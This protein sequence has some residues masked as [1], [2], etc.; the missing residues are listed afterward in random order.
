MSERIDA[1]K[2][3]WTN[4]GRAGDLLAAG[5]SAA[6]SAAA[7][8]AHTQATLALVEQQRIANLI[9]LGGIGGGPIN[10][11]YP[12]EVLRYLR[13]EY[14]AAADALRVQEVSRGDHG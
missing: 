3:A 14:P 8:I 11:A 5:I 13:R 4:L 1:A 9:A 10:S 7:H 2:E 6:A 12:D